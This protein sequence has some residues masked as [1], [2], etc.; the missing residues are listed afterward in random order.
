MSCCIPPEEP[1]IISLQISIEMVIPITNRHNTILVFDTYLLF[2]SSK[3]SKNKPI[4]IEKI[5][6]VYT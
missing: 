5:V 6:Q 3:E 1:I 2:K 4:A